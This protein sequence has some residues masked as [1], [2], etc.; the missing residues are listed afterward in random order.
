[1]FKSQLK[2]LP[3]LDHNML[4]LC[5][6]EWMLDEECEAIGPILPIVMQTPQKIERRGVYFDFLPSRF[7]KWVKWKYESTKWLAKLIRLCI[8]SPHEL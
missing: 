7:I 3:L 8:E 4:L 1:M 5:L 2:L 6:L